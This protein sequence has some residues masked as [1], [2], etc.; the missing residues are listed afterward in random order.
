MSGGVFISYR[1]EDSAGFARLIYDRLARRLGPENVFIDVDNIKPGLDFVDVLNERLSKCD[2]L[3]AVIGKNWISAAD[4]D[5]RRRIDDPRDFVGLEIRA[6]LERGVRVI[7]VLID[8]AT[9]PRLD[10]LPDSLKKLAR[11]HGIEISHTRFDS[12][13]ERVAK[14]LSFLE[15]EFR[16]REAAEAERAREEQEKRHA[17]EKAQAAEQARRLAYVDDPFLR[18]LSYQHG[19]GVQ[20][21]YAQA[22]AWYRKAADQGNADAQYNI[23]VLYHNGRGV[24]QDYAQ[25]KAWFQKAADQGSA[26]AQFEMA[27]TTRTAWA[28]GRTTPRRRRGT[29]RPPIRGTKPPRTL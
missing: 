18:G 17:A 12:D 22:M 13:I 1:R 9:M 8:G 19:L 23:G 5:N 11:R 15:E 24:R 10:E 26:A 29:R 2:A 6:A 27:N 25:A 3:V 20:Q 28:S 4:K 16:Q 14:S 7:P 21:D